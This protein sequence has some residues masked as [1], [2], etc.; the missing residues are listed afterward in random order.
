MKQKILDN[1]IYVT[2]FGI[3]I[4]LE[5]TMIEFAVKY[6]NI[7]LADDNSY[8]LGV[9]W[10][11]IIVAATLAVMIWKLMRQARSDLPW[12]GLLGQKIAR[13][14]KSRPEIGWWA[15]RILFLNMA[16]YLVISGF[17]LEFTIR[18]QIQCNDYSF[19]LECYEQI[20][21]LERI[22]PIISQSALEW[23]ASWP[24]GYIIVS[25]IISTFCISLG[26]CTVVLL[27]ARSEILRGGTIALILIFI[28]S[29]SES[30]YL[31]G[32][33]LQGFKDTFQ[34]FLIA[35]SIAIISLM[36]LLTR[37]Y[38]NIFGKGE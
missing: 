5:K 23:M 10:L 21:M 28:V 18:G 32:S 14:F 20:R 25:G 27:I 36:T 38:K 8:N 19:R 26:T 30:I 4:W 11:S 3:L 15:S 22:Y 31:L 9:W 16:I 13:F 17:V 7:P 6:G 37:E 2:I 1:L 12:V 29:A 34:A 35:V 33:S 24:L